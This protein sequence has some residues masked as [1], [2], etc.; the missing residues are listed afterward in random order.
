M[1]VT[2]LFL[3]RILSS[4]FLVGLLVIFLTNDPSS[5]F[6]I[7]YSKKL[8]IVVLPG[9]PLPSSKLTLSFAVSLNF[10]TSFSISYKLKKSILGPRPIIYIR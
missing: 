2:F 4:I 7:F 1:H 3:L 8:D 6:L 5:E 9:A 10:N